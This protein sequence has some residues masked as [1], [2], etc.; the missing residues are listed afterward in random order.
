MPASSLREDLNF[1]AHRGRGSHIWDVS[2]NEYIDWLI[3]AGP[4]V[5]SHAHPNVV[6]AVVDAVGQG[7]TFGVTNDKAVLLAEE[8]G[9][10]VPCAEK[11][12][13]VTS[14]TDA[15]FHAMRVARAH[16]NREKVLKFEGAYHGVSDYALMS[17]TPPAGEEFPQAVPSSAGIPKAIQELMLIAPSTTWIP[18]QQSSKPTT[19]RWRRFWWSPSSGR[20]RPSRAF[21]RACAT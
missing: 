21:Y 4:I 2:V 10:A 19:M 5:L 3:G 1:L 7:S 18:R 17:V 13:F 20:Y 9:R 12:R 11:V 6:K 15:N 8:L 14:G 16:R